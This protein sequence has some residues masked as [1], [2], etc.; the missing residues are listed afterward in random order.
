MYSQ[1]SSLSVGWFLA[2]RDIK[3]SN[4][5]TTALIVFVMM[6]TFFNMLLLGGI[7]IGVAEGL[8]ASFRSSYSSDLLIT[9]SKQKT[10]IEETNSVVQVVDNVPGLQAVSV[11]YTAPATID[12][13]YQ[14]KVRD[15][16]KAESTSGTLTGINP[17]A[18][19]DVTGMSSKVVAGAYLTPE[20]QDAIL[21]GGDLTVKYASNGPAA[22]ALSE[23][24][25][26]T[27]DVGSR[28]RLTVNGIQ[29]EV[30]VKGIVTTGNT[31]MDGRIYMTDTQVINLV[32]RTSL[33]ANEMAIKLEPTASPGDAKTFIAENLENNP[34]ILVKTY[35]EA[36]PSSSAS[37]TSTFTLLSNIVGFI[38]L[39]V[40][41]ITIFIVIY[42][43]AITRRK[44][45]GILKGIGISVNA[46]K[47]S[48][49][50]QALFYAVSGIILSS[51][52]LLGY[53]VPYFDIHPLVL[54]LGKSSL[55][56]DLAGIMS[57]AAILTITAF[58][59][60]F[61]PAWLVVKQNTLDAILGR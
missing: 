13:A 18:E 49:V 28:V 37:I 35:Y 34:N 9:P 24:A 23:N 52:L 45:I 33:N 30:L 55:A 3:R 26:K 42:V 7:L 39:I 20:D 47:I 54:P 17:I 61:I 29:R 11:R 21:L 14:T 22:G 1:G 19:N 48:Y 5:W 12:Y 10:V 50:I 41:A 40:G 53:I 60:G 38:A 16:D 8:F 32:R 36:I 59:S 58:I 43:N 51:I 46:I 2:Q 6:L 56:I 25:L 4:P 57:R 44:Y 15:S 27:A 31:L